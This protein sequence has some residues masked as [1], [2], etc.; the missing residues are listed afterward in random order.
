[1]YRWETQF[2]ALFFTG[3]E[4]LITERCL[5]PGAP[6]APQRGGHG[7]SALSAPQEACGGEIPSSLRRRTES[8][9]LSSARRVADSRRADGHVFGTRRKNSACRELRGP[10][11]RCGRD[12]QL[13]R[14]AMGEDKHPAPPRRPAPSQYVEPHETPPR[15]MADLFANR[16]RRRRR[17]THEMQTRRRHRGHGTAGGGLSQ[18][19]RLT[20]AV[21]D[22]LI[23]STCVSRR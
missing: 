4:H 1:M 15:L 21:G 23:R 11:H 10:R 22:V 14:A 16:G 8:S 12:L 20:C 2:L 9:A 13:Y 6:A 7:S 17:W 3:I 5:I 19:F 18:W